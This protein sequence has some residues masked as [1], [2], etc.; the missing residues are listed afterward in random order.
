MLG[1]RRE[2]GIS[3]DLALISLDLALTSLD[4]AL[5]SLELA[6][7]SLVEHGEGGERGVRTAADDAAW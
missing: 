2:G 6:L 5:T 1:G 3:L 4:L 7:I